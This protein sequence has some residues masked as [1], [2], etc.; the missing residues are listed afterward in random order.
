MLEPQD[1]RFLLWS[2]RRTRVVALL[3]FALLAGVACGNAGGVDAT[4]G[5]GTGGGTT[6][7]GG[8][9]GKGASSS[10]GGKAGSTATGG[11]TGKG[12]AAAMGTGGDGAGPGGAS[13]AGC[14]PMA[15]DFA[16]CPCSMGGM[17]HAC[18]PGAPTTRGVGAC[19]DGVQV[20][21]SSSEL[22]SM[23]GPCSGAKLPAK[24]D[25]K[26][27]IDNDCNGLVDCA[28]PTCAQDAACA[29]ACTDGM[30][31]ACYDGP[32][33]TAGVG[34][35]KAGT[36]TCA[37][38]KWPTTCPGEIGPGAETCA[39]NTDGDCN[40]KS[41]CAD[42]ACANAAGCVKQC[43][44]GQTQAC[45]TGP[46]GSQN[47]GTC[48]AGMRT[49]VGGMWP[50]ECPG[51]VLPANENCKDVLDHNCN[52]FKGCDDIFACVLDSYCWGK[53]TSPHPGCTC[54]T[55][56]GDTATCPDGSYGRAG[57]LGFGTGQPPEV[58]CCPCTKNDCGNASCCGEAVCAGSQFCAGFSCNKLPASC[59]GKVNFDCDFEDANSGSGSLSEDCDEP[60][61]RC[62]SGC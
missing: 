3:S 56:T 31:R 51:E 23:F 30:T 35:C 21:T 4:P 47:V 50:V 8:G 13:G 39:A 9:T 14:D 48:K 43:T 2:S 49:C 38:G 34:P 58:E 29:G 10:T 27:T 40:G 18:Y 41:G 26:D 45:Y 19:K 12:G 28:D 46:A 54:P 59:G 52:G 25:C 36:Q 24:E 22:G 57:A 17:M 1:E 55:G 62:H 6:A 33:G 32:P 53:C 61:C 7:A 37:G 60:C 15:S 11:A 44:D 42:A 20:C 5:A 16:G